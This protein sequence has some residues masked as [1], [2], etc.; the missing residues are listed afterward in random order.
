VGG[1]LQVDE[2]A[3]QIKR[4][5][6]GSSTGSMDSVA[7]VA[8]EGLRLRTEM[9]RAVE[10]ERW[11]CGGATGAVLAVVQWRCM[12]CALVLHWCCIGAALAALVLHWCCWSG[13]GGA[14]VLHL[15]LPWCCC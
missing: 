1:C 2:A 12:W 7:D 5:Q 10:Q 3:T 4:Q 15:V 13:V 8:T 11:A 14:V 6:A 9:Q